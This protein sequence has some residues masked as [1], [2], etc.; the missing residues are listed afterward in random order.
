MD[1]NTIII[2]LL[3]ALAMVQSSQIKNL[4]ERVKKLEDENN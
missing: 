1:I 3:V 2:L 4:K